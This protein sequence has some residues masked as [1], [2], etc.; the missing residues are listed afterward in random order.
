M[1]HARRRSERGFSLLE[2]IVS[3]AILAGTILALTSAM[4]GSTHDTTKLIAR[5]TLTDVASDVL[6]DLRVSSAYQPHVMDALFAQPPPPFVVTRRD[7]A[8][9]ALAVTVA[10][11]LA[12]VPG[13]DGYAVSITATAPDGHAETLQ[14]LVIQ[15]AVAPGSTVTPAPPTAGTAV[16][17]IFGSSFGQPPPLASAS[18]A[19][20][21]A[22]PPSTRTGGDFGT[23]LDSQ[24]CWP[25]RV[26]PGT[27]SL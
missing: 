25:R 23:C 15:Q 10:E 12:R 5:Q 11:R 16:P 9:N 3:I 27:G 4:L 6:T 17:G 20:L 19:A 7:A 26:R 18:G 21:P 24:G 22:S 8:G 1:Q 14:Q 2:A 13:S